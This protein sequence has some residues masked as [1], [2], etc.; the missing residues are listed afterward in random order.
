[1]ER[2]TPYGQQ[3]MIDEKEAPDGYS[4][5]PKAAI[6]GQTNYC[7]ACDWRSKCSS[8]YPC[9]SDKRKDGISVVF[10]KPPVIVKHYPGQEF[11]YNFEAIHSY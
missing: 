3:V 1:M 8:A 6:R 7:N 4:P 10:K 11:V 2:L 9:M 5:I